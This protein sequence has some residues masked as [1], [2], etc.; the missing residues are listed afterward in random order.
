V[1]E[2]A[3]ACRDF[4]ASNDRESGKNAKMRCNMPLFL[5]KPRCRLRYPVRD[6]PRILMARAG[7]MCGDRRLALFFDSAETT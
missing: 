5:P 4:A 6:N 2:Q 7:G 1:K 3:P